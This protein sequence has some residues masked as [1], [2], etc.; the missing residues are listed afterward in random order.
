MFDG[1]LLFEKH[2]T[3]WTKNTQKCRS[4]GRHDAFFSLVTTTNMKTF[5][6][7]V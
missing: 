6:Q 1:S 7:N 2:S 3:K 5:M 4:R